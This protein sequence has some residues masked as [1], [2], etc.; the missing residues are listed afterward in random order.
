M[1]LTKSVPVDPMFVILKTL[2][3][4]AKVF[5][6]IVVAAFKTDNSFSQ[7]ENL[8]FLKKVVSIT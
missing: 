7:G 2:L 1:I 6:Y 3:F 5:S 4:Y 8:D